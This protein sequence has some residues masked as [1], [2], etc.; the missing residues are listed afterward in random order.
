MAKTKVLNGLAYSLA[1][2]YFSTLNYCLKGYM[3]DWIVNCAND[4]N[5]DFVK[6]DL[7]NKKIYPKELNDTP[8][9]QFLNHFVYSIKKT[10]KNND[11]PEDFII[12][13]E[14]NIRILKNRQ[15]ICSCYTKG[16][17][18]RIYKSKDYLEQS[19]TVF[20]ALNP[21]TKKLIKRENITIF[22]KILFSFWRKLF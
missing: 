11:L 13:A 4:L 15:I 6:I 16:T 14:F 19:Y 10:L 5:I 2:S 8:L 7:L 21:I 12:E 20:N 18:N 1:Q 22:E 3:S 9:S 17:N